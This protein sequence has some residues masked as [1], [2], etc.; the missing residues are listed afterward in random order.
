MRL[1]F[2]MLFLQSL[3][4][5]A[6]FTPES[7]T[8]LA[9]TQERGCGG[10]RRAALPIGWDRGFVAAEAYEKQGVNAY[11]WGKISGLQARHL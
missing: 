9:S 5:A 8:P 2:I 6:L 1:G 11:G 7:T 4:L 10:M 3:G